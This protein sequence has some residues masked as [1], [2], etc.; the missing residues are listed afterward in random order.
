LI[1]RIIIVVGA[2]A[3][4]A[5]QA[6]RNASV[7]A[8]AETRPATAAKF[9][10]DHPATELSLG[11]TEIA[12]A[13]RERKKVP[14]EAFGLIGDAAEKD[15]LASG[16]FLVR[17]VSAQ[18]A[19]NGA[20]AER[21]FEAAQWRD[22]R[23]LPAAYFL[24]QRYL[25]SGD[26]GRGL[27]EVATLARLAPYGVATVTP[28]L[29]TYA[30]V[31]ANWPRLR[32][33]FRDNPALGGPVLTKLATNASTVPAVLALA[34]PRQNA[35]DAPWLP[36]LLNTM[37]AAGQYDQARSIWARSS[38]MPSTSELVHDLSFTDKKSPPPFNWSLTSSTVGLAE[39]QAGGRL[40][41]VFYGQEDGILASQ[42]LLLKPGSY[43]LSMQLFGDPERARVLNWSVWC[44]KTDAP[45]ASVG[46]DAAAARGWR[47]DVP[48]GC[49]A[50]WLKL[51]GSSA[52]VPQQIDVSIGG[53]RLERSAPGA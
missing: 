34:D 18:L 41:V 53:L 39:R 9:W 42:L 21:A 38:G 17:G 25:E 50:Q 35:V 44:D 20:L 49:P 27:A 6:V 31:A 13:T 16:P 5:V 2:A 3:L 15:P 28:Y 26:S 37:V 45:I 32:Q 10:S 40:Q 7:A 14:Q 29:A 47:F 51:S 23:S 24:A 30:S 22:P 4:I 46:L 33:L 52:D 1:A 36:P 8:F 19:G 12:Q 43:R 48:A 11:L